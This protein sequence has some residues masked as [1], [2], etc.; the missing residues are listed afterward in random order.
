MLCSRALI[1]TEMPLAAP[2]MRPTELTPTTSAKFSRTMRMVARERRRNSGIIIGSSRPMTT[3][4]V[5]MAMSVDLLP[6]ETPT[7]A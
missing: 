3:S 4:L 7:S 6:R 5:S 2:R 1:I